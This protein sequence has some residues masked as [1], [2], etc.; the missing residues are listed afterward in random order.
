MQISATA[1]S[2]RYPTIGCCNENRILNLYS[3][4]IEFYT[5]S[6]W[7]QAHTGS[8]YYK[9][10]STIPNDLKFHY[11]TQ[12]GGEGTVTGPTTKEKALTLESG[13][14]QPKILGA[15]KVTKGDQ[16]TQ[17]GELPMVLLRYNP[18]DDTGEGN[19]VTIVDIVSGSWQGPYPEQYTIYNVP[20]LVSIKWI[21]ELC[22][23]KKVGDKGIIET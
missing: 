8:E 10:Y 19:M 17:Y 18:A 22:Y 11:K 9:P 14:F 4:N 15:Y 16:V 13:W 3:L 21:C 1:A 2:F 7:A 23:N 5:D 12:T 6:H 20:T